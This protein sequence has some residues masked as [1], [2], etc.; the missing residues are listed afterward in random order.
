MKRFLTLFMALL[1]SITTLAIAPEQAEQNPKI[2][3]SNTLSI[4]TENSPATSD[5]EI[6]EKQTESVD[7]STT[8]P[9]A[10]SIT[11]EETNVNAQFSSKQITPKAATTSNHTPNGTTNPENNEQKETSTPS[12][13]Q[14]TATIT[15]YCACSKCNGKYSYTDSDGAVYCSTAGGVKLYNGRNNGNYCAANFGK[16]GDK[17]TINGTTY[18][19]IDRFGNSSG[20]PKVDIFVSEGHSTCMQKGRQ[21]GVTVTLH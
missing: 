1:C 5:L 10:T 8:E 3:Y 6:T 15:H 2:E 18:T 7:L 9:I 12:G 16:L 4:Q 19:I 14:I 20:A 17:I 21:T 13:K 11:K